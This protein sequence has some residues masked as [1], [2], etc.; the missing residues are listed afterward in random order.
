M[1]CL[2]LPVF[3]LGWARSKKGCFKVVCFDFVLRDMKGCVSD[4][5]AE[6]TNHTNQNNLIL[7]L[8]NPA[9]IQATQDSPNL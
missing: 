4:K 1:G 6:E 8:P 7:L 2:E 3:G 9:Q 5:E